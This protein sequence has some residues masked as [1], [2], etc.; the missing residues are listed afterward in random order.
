LVNPTAY[1]ERSI[2]LALNDNRNS[3]IIYAKNE[4]MAPQ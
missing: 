2:H 3:E 1:K 4:Y